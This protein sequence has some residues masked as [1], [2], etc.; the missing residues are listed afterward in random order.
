LGIAGCLQHPKID[1][2]SPK[3]SLRVVKAVAAGGR[4]G[5]GDLDVV[6]F[7]GIPYPGPPCIANSIPLRD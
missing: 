3:L 1:A 4:V 2:M 7:T 6:L 5:C